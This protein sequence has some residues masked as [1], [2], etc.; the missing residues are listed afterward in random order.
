[1]FYQDPVVPL[2]SW[3]P[4]RL[5][6]T[7]LLSGNLQILFLPLY[8]LLIL[9]VCNFT[10]YKVNCQKRASSNFYNLIYSPT[11]TCEPSPRAPVLALPS[12]RYR[13]SIPLHPSSFGLPLF[14][15]N[16]FSTLYWVTLLNVRTS[17]YCSRL[18]STASWPRIPLLL[19]LHSS[20]PL[21]ECTLPLVNS[22]WSGFH[23]HLPQR[24]GGC[25]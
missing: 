3:S 8:L 7:S 12:P 24:P 9:C 17:C 2:L 25:L 11:H 13:S 20:A 14:P 16:H 21:K 18:R 10:S 1:M 4:R 6:T 19:L 5:C 23:P 22:L 15:Q